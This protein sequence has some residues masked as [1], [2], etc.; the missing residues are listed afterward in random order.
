M[1]TDAEYEKL[2]RRAKERETP[3]GT[4]AYRALAGLL[5]QQGEI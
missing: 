1:L 4:C 5:R 3:V 2:R